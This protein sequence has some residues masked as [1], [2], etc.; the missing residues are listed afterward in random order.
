MD[1]GSLAATAAGEVTTVWRRDQRLYR[2]TADGHVEEHLGT[3]MQPW[4]A[5]TASGTWLTWISRRGGDLWLLAPGAQQPKKLAA[6]A[7][8]P[9][10]ATGA[11]GKDSVL[12]LW[13]AGTGNDTAIMSMIVTS[14]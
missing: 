8:E 10:I 5:A 11:A 14:H 4:A 9:V 3:G 13:E 12:L 6:T 2:T 7:Y 1:G